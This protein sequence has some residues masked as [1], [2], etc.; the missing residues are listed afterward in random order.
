MPSRSEMARKRGIEEAKT[1]KDQPAY[2]EKLTK[3]AA[4]KAAKK[5]ADEMKV[6]FE[7]QEQL[8]NRAREAFMKFDLDES[9]TVDIVEFRSML[10]EMGVLD[11][12]EDDDRQKLVDE[13]FAHFDSDNN[14]TLDFNEFSRAYNRFVSYRD[15][16]EASKGKSDD[17]EKRVAAMGP[18]LDTSVFAARKRSSE[19]AAYFDSN[20]LIEK[21]FKTDWKRVES[22]P[23]FA[24]F[25]ENAKLG[26]VKK[27]KLE[28][29]KEGK[30][31]KKAMNENYAVLNRLFS[32]FSAYA[33]DGAMHGMDESEF[34]EFASA[35]GFY[36]GA[37]DPA[38]PVFGAMDLKGVFAQVNAEVEAPEGAKVSKK[39]A[40]ENAANEDDVMLRFEF[41]HCII[42]MAS[43]FPRGEGV[44]TLSAQ[45]ADFLKYLMRNVDAKIPP[46]L[47]DRN[48]FRR[49]RLYNAGVLDT[50]LKYQK[51]IRILYSLC[52]GPDF[53]P[54]TLAEFNWFMHR[55]DIFDDR[56]TRRL[57]PREIHLMFTW[58]QTQVSDEIKARDDA[59]SLAFDEFLEVICRLA[60]VK[61]LPTADDLRE[62]DFRHTVDALDSAVERLNDGEEPLIAR[63]KSSDFWGMDVKHERTLSE[64]IDAFLDYA[65]AMINP[66]CGSI[67][68]GTFDQRAFVSAAEA[69][70][71]TLYG[72]EL[73]A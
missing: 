28:L 49:D 35:A 36:Q 8:E 31:L 62:H 15:Q 2:D 72:K 27:K 22:S 52:V 32:F 19:S 24:E 4:K 11:D 69:E 45:A 61:D 54:I 58:S 12:V 68:L 60:D 29:N 42:R 71:L 16:L 63:R 44:H 67:L 43:L 38:N 65:F 26:A 13:T 55:L 23:S 53:N 64:R 20:E 66:D 7:E 48:I 33:A 21:A 46:Q 50:L 57:T 73:P 1:L 37:F 5:Q 70:Y 41:I 9:M 56:K 14:K 25:C 17:L 18:M 30:E 40:A 6:F 47:I 59:D 3:K 10:E 39:K 51:Q 34:I